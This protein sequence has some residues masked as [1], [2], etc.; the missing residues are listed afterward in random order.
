MGELARKRSARDLWIS[1]SHL[2]AGGLVVLLAL[3]VSFLGGYTLGTRRVEPGVAEPTLTGEVGDDELVELLARID[4]SSDPTGGLGSLSF[5][6]E[7]AS[8]E[9]SATLPDP[10]EEEDPSAVVQPG[11]EEVVGEVDPVP[12]GTWT[13]RVAS[14][15]EREE[16]ARLKAALIER[17]LPAW[18][19][20]ERVG[21]EATWQVSVGGYPDERAARTALVALK[22]SLV[23][24]PEISGADVA[25]LQ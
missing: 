5:P 13:I 16:A 18:Q 10:Q 1:R 15:G 25:E 6:D 20:M 22:A 12:P 3:G 24:V 11:F 2:W 7:L 9:A 23:G 19:R 14:L 8:T 17:E 21:G 4:A